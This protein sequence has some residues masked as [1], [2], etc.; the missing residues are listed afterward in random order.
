MEQ[1]EHP[2]GNETTPFDALGGEAR[3]EAIVERFYDLIEA[4]APT[5]R[6]MLPADDSVSR[7]K[8]FKYLVEW[9][10][11]PELYTPERGHPM[12]RKRHLPFSIG[13]DEADTWLTCMA[14]SLDDN[15]VKGKVRSFLDEKLTVL[16][17]H[18]RNT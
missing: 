11:G 18:M 15:D 16:A 4:D 1:S 17:G 5:L 7:Q 6:S 2:W 8:L 13:H 10:G 3:I 9:T 14:R 12:L